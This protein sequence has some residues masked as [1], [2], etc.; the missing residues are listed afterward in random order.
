MVEQIKERRQKERQTSQNET[1]LGQVWK[2]APSR[3]AY[4]TELA[5]CQRCSRKIA[6]KDGDDG[7][8]AA[9]AISSERGKMGGGNSTKVEAAQKRGQDQNEERGK[10]VEVD[11]AEWFGVE[12][13]EEIHEEEQKKV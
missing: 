6:E 13:R 5:V 8:V 11:L 10:A 7:E 3:C 2:I 1:S 4:G 9:A 12:Y